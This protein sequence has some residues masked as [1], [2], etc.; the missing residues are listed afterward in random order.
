MNKHGGIEIQL[1]D[2]TIYFKEMNRGVTMAQKTPGA[3]APIRNNYDL[4]GQNVCPMMK[5]SF[6]ELAES[7]SNQSLPLLNCDWEQ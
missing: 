7:F 5:N 4:Y 2:N 3:P 1:Y 6:L